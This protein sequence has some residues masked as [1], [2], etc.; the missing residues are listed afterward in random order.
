MES[1]A[2]LFADG[3]KMMQQI[4]YEVSFNMSNNFNQFFKQ[5]SGVIRALFA[6]G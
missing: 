1:A 2:E 4:T 6:T 3:D 5:L